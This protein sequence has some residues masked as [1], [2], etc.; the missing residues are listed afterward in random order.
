MGSCSFWRTKATS[1]Y[2]GRKSPQIS[3]LFST[4]TGTARWMPCSGRS[5]S[6]GRQAHWDRRDEPSSRV[7][8][9]VLVGADRDLPAASLFC[10]FWRGLW[11]WFA[12][13]WRGKPFS[14]TPGLAPPPRQISHLARSE[15][16]GLSSSRT[17][18]PSLT[19]KLCVRIS[20]VSLAACCCS[21]S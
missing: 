10:G 8:A 2:T 11:P 17:V 19:H 9:R 3:K 1:P 6:A 4:E 15:P 14:C 12:V 7:R 5:R 21:Y 18:S 13:R 20:P 16:R